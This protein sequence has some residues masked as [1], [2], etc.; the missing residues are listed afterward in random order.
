MSVNHQRSRSIMCLWAILLAGLALPASAQPA[1]VRIGQAVPTL[2]F[3]PLYAA[4]ALDT[5]EDQELRL[6]LVSIRG[7]DPAALAALDA[8]DIDFAAVGSDTALAAIAKGQPFAFIYS[9]MS[10]VSLQL[11][12]SNDL[13]KRAGVRPA[14]PL[15]TRILALKGAT[16]GVSAVGGAQDRMARW[17]AAQGGLDPQR[18]LKIAMI[19]PPPAIHAAL[20]NGQI[21]GFILSPP[22]G[23]LTE[24]AHV[25]TV[26]IRLG[27]EFAD[28][29][30]F[31][32]LVLVAKKP[33]DDKQRDLAV[34]TVRALEAASRATLA[35]PQRVADAIQKP[36]FP[37][38]A[39]AVVLAA[40]DAM[41]GGIAGEGRI[42]LE[43]VKHL[44]QLTSATGEPVTIDP[45]PGPEAFWTDDVIDAAL[46]GKRP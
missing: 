7:G 9:L 25:G 20:E 2:S 43:Q 10:E 29:R 46:R 23:M 36:F 26:L 31:P 27:A 28:L 14:D 35:D 42:S 39:P 21:D 37:K 18:D 12:V 15:P 41:K 44:L 3:L 38:L 22:E 30:S 40:V 33:L 8:G 6:E 45:R 17:L 5:F 32:Y 16:I 4:R 1:T 11:V 13:L 34:K 19:G 24:E